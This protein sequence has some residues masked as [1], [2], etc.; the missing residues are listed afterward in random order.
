MADK[1]LK[2]HVRLVK[3]VPGPAF[4]G[5]RRIVL[6]E[7]VRSTDEVQQTAYVWLRAFINTHDVYIPGDPVYGPGRLSDIFPADH[8][9]GSP[10][11]Q[12]GVSYV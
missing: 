12:V 6:F 7:G 11:Y 5:W 2:V 4:L 3:I 1:P 10:S 9:I 8:H